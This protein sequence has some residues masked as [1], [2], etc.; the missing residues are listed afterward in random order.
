MNHEHGQ[1]GAP[2]R[3]EQSAGQLQKQAGW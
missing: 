1:M 3:R 2:L